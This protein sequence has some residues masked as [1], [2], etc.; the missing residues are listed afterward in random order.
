MSQSAELDTLGFSASQVKTKSYVMLVQGIL[1][2]CLSPTVKARV[3][4]I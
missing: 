3:V 4:D 1:F 2:K